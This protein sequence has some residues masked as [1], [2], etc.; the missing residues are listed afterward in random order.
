MGHLPKARDGRLESMRFFTGQYERSID[1]KNRVQ[2]PSQFRGQIGAKDERL[3]FVVTFGE[4][5]GTLCLYTQEGY[6]EVAARMETE[7]MTGPESRRF[8]LQFY[9]LSTPAEMDKQGRIVLPDRFKKK[10]GLGEE[11]VL[12]GQKNRIEI[13]SRDA[14][15]KAVGIDWDGEDWPEWQSFLRQR[16]GGQG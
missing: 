2:L 10:A 12:V 11:V 7:Y 8:E 14:F 15:E 1:G 6:E 16:P 13:W 5:R 4:S 3:T 9:G